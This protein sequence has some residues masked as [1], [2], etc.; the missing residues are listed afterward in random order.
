MSLF[1][2]GVEDK[3]RKQ[4]NQLLKLS[5]LINWERFRKHFR[6]FYK[7]EGADQ[8]GQRPYDVVKMYKAVLLGQWHGLSDEELEQSLLVKCWLKVRMRRKLMS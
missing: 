4:N 2:F 6:G 1:A 5:E 8:G 3:L 7:K